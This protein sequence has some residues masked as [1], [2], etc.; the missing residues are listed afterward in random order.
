MENLCQRVSVTNSVHLMAKIML[1]FVPYIHL[2]TV[3]RP[4]LTCLWWHSLWW[5]EI[6]P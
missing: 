2:W 3:V 6:L 5:H 4:N 1:L